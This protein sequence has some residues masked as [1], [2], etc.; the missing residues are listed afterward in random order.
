[1]KKHFVFL[2]AILSLLNACTEE[3]KDTSTDN[4]SVFEASFLDAEPESIIPEEYYS[5][6]VALALLTANDIRFDRKVVSGTAEYT[7]ISKR[8]KTYSLSLAATSANLTITTTETATVHRRQTETTT[9]TFTPGL[10]RQKESA[11]PS[12]PYVCY[13]RITD[14]DIRICYEYEEGKFA[15]YSPVVLPLDKGTFVSRQ[16]IGEDHTHEEELPSQTHESMLNAVTDPNGVVALRNTNYTFHFTPATGMLTQL[17]PEY[18][19]IGVLDR[20]R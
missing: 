17:E 18:K 6:E 8:V 15:D 19:E 4:V 9:Y 20:M 11:P 5:P 3:T 10:Y 16:Y 2:L 13:L 1:M 7:N 14:N 12:I